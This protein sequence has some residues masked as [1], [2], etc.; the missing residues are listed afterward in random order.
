MLDEAI[1]E[2]KRSFEL[3]PDSA[4]YVG[5]L[6]I[7]SLFQGHYSQASSL[8]G[9]ELSLN[10]KV[11]DG[12]VWLSQSYFYRGLN[13][14]AWRAVEEGLEVEPQNTRAMS[15][16]AV[17]SAAVG[18]SDEA[19]RD[20]QRAREIFEDHHVQYNLGC[21]YALMK[22]SQ[23]AVKWLK[24][25]AEYGFT[26]YPWYQRDPLLDALRNDPR[27]TA[28]MSGCERSGKKTRL[29]CNSIKEHGYLRTFK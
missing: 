12:Y 8:L 29:S 6:G 13:D 22:E 26:C 2:T 1:R 28:F 15:W 10:P 7:Y 5:R 20:A 25:S 9:K 23:Q 11:S 21:M 24:K 19:R 3:N 17:L 14:K 4:Q 18:K 27:F 16:R